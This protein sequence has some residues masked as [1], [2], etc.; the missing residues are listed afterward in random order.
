VP[1]QPKKPK[2]V[3]C[4]EII[5]C[6]AS[7]RKQC[8]AVYGPQPIIMTIRRLADCRTKAT[9]DQFRTVRVYA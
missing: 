2:A 8:N 6:T 1:L 5:I 7:G 9:L 3:I 4:T